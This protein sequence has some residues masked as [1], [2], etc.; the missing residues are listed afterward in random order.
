MKLNELK[1]IIE[2]GGVYIRESYLTKKTIIELLDYDKVKIVTLNYSQSEKIK[3]Q[4]KQKD[5]LEDSLKNQ[6]YYTIDF[7][8]LNQSN[9]LNDAPK[10][11]SF[12]GKSNSN[13]KKLSKLYMDILKKY[14]I[15]YKDLEELT[16]NPLKKDCS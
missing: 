6:H 7:E 4:E 12:M 10:K 2:K 1:K 3:K 14:D 5:N 11:I 9:Q 16:K 13:D 15:E 8:E